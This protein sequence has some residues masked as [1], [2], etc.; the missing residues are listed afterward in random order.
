MGLKGRDE[1]PLC[2]RAVSQLGQTVWRA[3][4]RKSHLVC[5]ASGLLEVSFPDGTLA[6]DSSFD[7]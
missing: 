5:A 7:S 3:A 4:D 6:V 1:V 2:T